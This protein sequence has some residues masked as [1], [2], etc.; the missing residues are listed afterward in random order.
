V[1]LGATLSKD[2]IVSL[3]I[4]PPGQGGPATQN[5][6]GAF[7]VATVNLGIADSITVSLNTGSA[8][9]PLTLAVCQTDPKTGLCGTSIL[10]TVTT[11]IN[12][13]DTPTFAVF[14]ISQQVIPL[15]PAVNRIFVVFT[16]SDGIVRGSTSVAVRTQ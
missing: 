4:L 15:D 10:P 5:F 9:L 11:Q 7:A 8:A 13:N 14:V 12:P 3:I 16:G 6:V 2:G 1:A